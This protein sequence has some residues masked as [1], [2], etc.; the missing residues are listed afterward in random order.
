MTPQE[1]TMSKLFPRCQAIPVAGHE[2]RFLIDS[3]HRLSWH[4]GTDYPR[5][6]FDPFIGPSGQSLTRMGHPGAPNHDHH[7]SIWF[8]HMNVTGIDFWLNG[9]PPVIRQK[10]W[11]AYVDSDD[12]AIMGVKLEWFDGHNP[13]P[14]MEQEV[15]ASVRPPADAESDDPNRLPVGE[16]LFEI[17]TTLTPVSQQ[18]ELGKTNFGLLAVRVAKNLSAVFGGGKLTNSEG[19]EGEKPIFGKP[20][21]WMDYSGPVMPAADPSMSDV[22]EGIT[23]FDH[24]SN[25]GHPAHWHVRNDGWMNASLCFEG[26]RL[27]TQSQPLTLRYLLYAHAGAYDAE[28]S[29]KTA[30]MFAGSPGFVVEKGKIPHHAWSI[31]RQPSV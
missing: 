4:F 17:Q 15:I 8:A 1:A 9:L 20:A 18:L 29:A 26:P 24:P 21:R 25:P 16:T 12:E 14:L 27:I 6:F 7:Q 30:E 10:E 23:Y 19:A 13:A 5:P 31:R 3:W 22:I 28:T 2:V 11:L